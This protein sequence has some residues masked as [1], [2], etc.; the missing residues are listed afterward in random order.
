M[1]CLRISGKLQTMVINNYENFA[2]V[3][4]LISKVESYFTMA[5]H[6]IS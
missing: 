6:S 5:Q 1:L 3:F 2:T 4:T